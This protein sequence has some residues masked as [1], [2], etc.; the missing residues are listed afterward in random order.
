MTKDEQW[1]LDE[2]YSGVKTPAFETDRKRLA[3]EEP[4]AYV[5]GWQPFLG[6]N[7]YL[8]SCPLIPRPETEWWTE[9]LLQSTN[10]KIG[11]ETRS[12][13]D[14]CAGSGAIGC[15]AL[16]QLPQYRIYFGE[17]EP[18]HRGTIEKNIQ[19]NTLDA[20]RAE[21]RIGDLF[22]PFVGLRFDAIAINPPYIPETRVLADTVTNWEP[23]VALRAGVDGLSIIRRIAET[24]PQY[25]TPDGEAWVECDSEH[26]VVVQQLFESQGLHTELRMDQYDRPRVIVVSFH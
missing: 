22:A 25:L 9:Q 26:A 2:K 23:A 17:L 12:F 21:I 15:A 6:L 7:I 18:A 10:Q 13:L 14:L 24:L 1:L 20:T 19:M 16:A 11:S 3:R 5:I 4:L 8:D